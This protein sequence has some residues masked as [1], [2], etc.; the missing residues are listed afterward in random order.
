MEYFPEIDIIPIQSGVKLVANVRFE[1]EGVWYVNKVINSAP[2]LSENLVKQFISECYYAS[3]FSIP[4]DKLDANG[5]PLTA[6]DKLQI[7]E[8]ERIA[9]RFNV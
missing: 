1:H 9:K 4:S 6:V 8:K 2:S 5:I 3:L 7:L